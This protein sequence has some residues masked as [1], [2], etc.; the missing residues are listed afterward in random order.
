[1]G[2]RGLLK[3]IFECK[4]T[5]RREIKANGKTT[6]V[7]DG[8]SM[9]GY[10]NSQAKYKNIASILDT[11]K[12]LHS[13]SELVGALKSQGFTRIVVFLDHYRHSEKDIKKWMNRNF[14]RKEDRIEAL[15]K[16]G[17]RR[18]KFKEFFQ[19]GGNMRQFGVMAL[20]F[21]EIYALCGCEVY[22]ACSTDA[23]QAIHHFCATES[24]VYGVISSDSDFALFTRIPRWILVKSLQIMCHKKHG[25][26][27]WGYTIQL[28]KY[29]MSQFPKSI[30][31][32]GIYGIAVLCGNDLHNPLPEDRGRF[33]VDKAVKC[34]RAAE[35]VR[36]HELFIKV[37]EY[38][39]FTHSKT[40]V[41]IK[42]EDAIASRLVD[43]VKKTKMFLSGALLEPLTS[44]TPVCIL[45]RPLR[46]ALY[47]KMG[48]GK[49]QCVQE[50]IFYVVD[51]KGYAKDF[52]RPDLSHKYASVLAWSGKDS[53]VKDKHEFRRWLMRKILSID[54]V[55]SNI[56]TSIRK[57]LMEQL[58][59]KIRED[60]RRKKMDNLSRLSVAAS[61]LRAMA[62][63]KSVGGII[64]AGISLDEKDNKLPS[65]F[66]EIFGLVDGPTFLYLLQRRMN[67]HALKKKLV[68]SVKDL[69][70]EMQG[71]C[72]RWVDE[73]DSFKVEN[74]KHFP[75]Y[76]R[77][78]RNSSGHKSRSSVNHRRKESP[79][80]SKYERKKSSRK[81]RPSL[82]TTDL[83]MKSLCRMYKG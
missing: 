30:P 58:D 76:K 40:K 34:L 23:D 53:K 68:R 43:N 26:S 82:N 5:N 1:M 4:A 15:R 73:D 52:V 14:E 29:L 17:N 70:S 55:K 22:F 28:K 9:T 72:W 19:K 78:P 2:V 25:L 12:M 66:H 27:I 83:N 7:I 18:I 36:R 74:Q 11:K 20:F 64:K 47:A 35:S 56:E 21:R 3:Y 54:I 65:V 71:S 41:S 61:D 37:K 60:V 57:L 51:R 16:L 49:S 80:S 39:D 32:Y 48:M 33:S 79:K 75:I 50:R 8:Y 77:V 67:T 69:K 62:I 38:Y 10:W 6:I 46:R 81:D 63:I 45:V 31:P 42:L 24:S 59:T 44:V 13:V